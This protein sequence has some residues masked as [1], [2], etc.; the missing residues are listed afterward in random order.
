MVLGRDP[1]LIKRSQKCRYAGRLLQRQEVR[2]HA[3]VRAADA[4]FSFDNF[5]ERVFLRDPCCLELK[6]VAAPDADLL[7]IQRRSGQQTFGESSVATGEMPI[8]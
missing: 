1:G 5:P 2:G 8:L 3:R 4:G 7:P 6:Q